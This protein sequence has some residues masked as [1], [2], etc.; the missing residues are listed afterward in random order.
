[1]SATPFP[2][3]ISTVALERLEALYRDVDAAIAA[4]APRCE[5]SGRCCDFDRFE[6]VL[7][8][9][10]LEVAYLLARTPGADPSTSALLSWKPDGKLCPFWKNRLCMA[11]EGRPLGCRIY[12]CDPSYRDRMP[13]IGEEYQRRLRTIHDDLDIEYRYAPLVESLREVHAR[14]EG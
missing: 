10:D 6:H 4:A 2:P 8:A 9:T 11:R 7:F 5:L 14:A 3:A 13:E 12:F 1:M